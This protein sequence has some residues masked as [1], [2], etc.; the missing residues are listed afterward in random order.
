ML[1]ILPAEAIPHQADKIQTVLRVR[2]EEE[3]NR[4]ALT[5]KLQIRLRQQQEKVQ[6]VVLQAEKTTTVLHL[7]LRTDKVRTAHPR[8]QVRGVLQ[9]QVQVRLHDK[10]QIQTIAEAV[11]P[12]RE[13][14]T[15]Q[16]RQIE[17]TIRKTVVQ[18]AHVLLR[19]V[20]PVL[21][22]E[23]VHQQDDKLYQRHIK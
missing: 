8:A 11:L 22:L 1:F 14:V 23:T 18:A 4:P 10:A 3:P 15:M 21:K 19:A 7:L 6:A 16:V 13:T 5:E 9:R 17:E 20:L 2:P 12:V